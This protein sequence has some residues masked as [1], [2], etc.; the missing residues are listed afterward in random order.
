[1]TCTVRNSLVLLLALMLAAAGAT[2]AFAS[3]EE[4]TGAAAMGELSPPGVVPIFE[5]K[6][7]MT[8]FVSYTRTIVDFEANEMTKWMEEQTNI[9]WEWDAVNSSEDAKA[10]FT[11]VM[12]SG[13]EL[14]DMMMGM[15]ITNDEKHL[16]GSQG[17]FIPLNDIIEEHGFYI[18]DVVKAAPNFLKE[19]AG[20]DGNVYVITAYEECYHCGVAQKMWINQVWLDK[21]GLEMPT[22]TEELREVLRAFKT[23]DPNGNGVADELPLSGFANSWH[24]RA[25]G[26][27]C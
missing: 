13:A 7:T 12:N 23:Q 6:V 27:T 24:T 3:G 16:Y 20:P 22:T 14:P 26:R 9:H 10:K 15:N 19:S 17:L 11:L 25:P 2:A 21:L 4:E 1:M 8:A 18:K 5:E